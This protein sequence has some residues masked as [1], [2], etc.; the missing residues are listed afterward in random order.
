MYYSGTVYVTA[1]EALM[2][3][4]NSEVEAGTTVDLPAGTKYT[5]RGLSVKLSTEEFTDFDFVL[6]TSDETFRLPLKNGT[7]G[8]FGGNAVVG[9]G[10]ALGLTN[11]SQTAGLATMAYHE[12]GRAH[13]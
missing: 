8:M 11:G 6:N 3:E 13:V 10:M 7:E 4:Y 1:Y 2:V 9:N 12:I 5:K